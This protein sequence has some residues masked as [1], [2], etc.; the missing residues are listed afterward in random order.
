M[1][2]PSSVRSRSTLTR[3]L[4]LALIGCAL[5]AAAPL[6]ALAADPTGQRVLLI[7]QEADP[8][9]ERVGAE[10]ES[11]GFTI[12]RSD[13]RGPLEVV[14]RETGA[15]AAIRMLP[16]RKGVEVWMADATSG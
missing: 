13:A 8:F 5:S 10:I 2:R 6:R 7:E 4:C 16:T 9:L 3:G 12:V 15:A 1:R 14:A 11:I